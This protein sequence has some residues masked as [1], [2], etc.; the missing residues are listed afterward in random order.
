LNLSPHGVLATH[1]GS[2]NLV[3]EASLAKKHKLVPALC[4]PVLALGRETEGNA[5]PG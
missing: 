2:D 1:K 4:Q 5:E 3:R